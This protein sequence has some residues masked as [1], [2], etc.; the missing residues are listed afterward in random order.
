MLVDHVIDHG[1][2]LDLELDVDPEKYSSLKK[3]AFALP[4]VRMFPIHT[5]QDALLSAAYLVKQASLLDESFDPVIERVQKALE[6]FG[7]KEE[8]KKIAAKLTPKEREQLPDSVFGLVIKDPK[9]GEKIRKYPMPDRNHVIAAIK[10]FTQ[11]Y[12]RY[13]EEWRRQIAKKIVQKAREFGVE[14]NSPVVLKYAGVKPQNKKAD[15]KKAAALIEAFRVDYFERQGLPEVGEVYKKLASAL[16]QIAEQTNELPE[17]E[18]KKIASAIENLDGEFGVTYE[19]LP[20]PTDIVW[21][22]E[23]DPTAGMVKLASKEYP[24]EVLKAIPD[25]V[26]ENLLGRKIDKA[27]LEEELSKLAYADKVILEQFLEQL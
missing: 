5:P 14:V 27:N 4:E 18:L 3:E 8:F 23:E 7:L 25:K 19:T 9:T 2:L 16:E 12:K 13:P 26:Y 20:S 10:Y 1:K 6:H 24:S 17:D 22:V 11:N 21:C 15:L